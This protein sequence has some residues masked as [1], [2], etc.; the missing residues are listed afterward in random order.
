MEPKFED[1]AVELDRCVKSL[2]E[3]PCDKQSQSP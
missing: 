1:A 2:T 3:G